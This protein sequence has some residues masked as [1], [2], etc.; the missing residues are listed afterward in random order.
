M[1]TDHIPR[2]HI[3]SDF[4]INLS[5]HT[6]SDAEVSLL[7]KG[8]SFIPTVKSFPL[9]LMESCIYRNLRN[10]KLRDYFFDKD[11]DD[12]AEYD[13]NAFHNKF[14]NRSTWI[15]ASNKLSSSCRYALQHLQDYIQNYIYSHIWHPIPDQP[16]RL[17]TFSNISD[18]LSPEERSAIRSLKNNNNILIKPADKGG[19]VVLLDVE[20][21]RAEGLRQLHN[22]DYYRPIPESSSR[23]TVSRINAILMRMRNRGFISYKQYSYLAADF[24]EDPRCFYLLPKVH[25][26]YSKW[27]SPSMP[28]GRPIVSDCSSETYHICELLDYYLQPLSIQNPAYLKDTY[29]FISR[30]RGRSI[31]ASSYLVTADVT[32]L[33][34]NM[35]INRSIE[36]VRSIFKE[37]PD[38]NRPDTELLE[39]LEIALT[40][41]EFSFDGKMFLQICGTAMGKGFAPSL[42][43]IYLRSFDAKALSYNRESL[44]FYGRFIDDIFFIWLA[45]SVELEAFQDYLNSLI[46]GIKV[47]FTVREILTEFLDT[48]V[49]LSTDPN[50]YNNSIINTQVFF[51]PTDT[52]Q[53]LH[54][55]SFH[56]RHTTKGIL[57]SQLI[58]FK[59]ISTSY[60]DYSN[61]CE[62]LYNVL[63]HRGYSRTYYR[64][65]K[66]SVW[67]TDFSARKSTPK[68][69]SIWPIVNYYD[70]MGNALG[71]VMRRTIQHLPCA[72][73]V[74]LISAHRRHRNLKDILTR[75]RFP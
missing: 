45:S 54:A 41:N 73:N 22:T 68:A 31:P 49:Y 19:A 35:H 8:L 44:A 23:N 24:P 32:A 46:P 47:T 28:E 34:T 63:R 37:F 38:H 55:S 53:L 52:H 6:L 15:P 4:I 66:Y 51:K 12:N 71:I 27:P 61:S 1:N 43:N 11:S 21:Y 64:D 69:D 67:Y 48:T 29:H 58:R 2:Q 57:K 16:A 59:R 42:A 30:I 20:S 50:D 39:L 74:R 65:L 40:T 18:N 56:P 33:Y 72:R 7:N 10:I 75:S 70:T 60:A 14:I 17:R 3:V 62:I 13:P 9:S 26:N 25:K 5:S 36:A